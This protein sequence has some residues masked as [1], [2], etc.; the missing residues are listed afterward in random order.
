MTKLSRGEFPMNIAGLTS[1][2]P[3]EQIWA[4]YQ[5][6]LEARGYMLRLRYRPDWVPEAIRLGKDPFDCEDS[7]P[8]EGKVLDATRI[9]DG[10]QVVLKI[11]ELL[12][13]DVTI[14]SFLANEQGAQKHTIS[15]LEWIPIDDT[16]GWMVMPRMRGCYDLP[17]F[18]TVRE[19]NEFLLQVLEGLV[20]LHSKNIA[21]RDICTQNIVMDASRI[22]PGGFHF[23]LPLTS[24]GLDFLKIYTG[25]ESEP[26]Y[27]KTRTEAG[28]TKYYYIDFGLSVRFPSFEARTLVTGNYGRLRKHVPEISD[29]VPYDPFKVDVRLVGEMLRFEFLE[30]YLGL[31]FV[32]PFMKELRRHSPANRPDAAMALGLF[33]QL[34]SR[35]SD[36]DLD[37]PV[38]FCPSV[39]RQT[40]K[41]FILSLKTFDFRWR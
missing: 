37:R 2:L 33:R 9:S 21:H 25:D 11:V 32:I 39:I 16:W 26:H 35:M 29:T 12:S 40:R 4:H 8:G 28:P 7:I 15:L 24:N 34:V 1:L 13:A 36:K 30:H 6:Y 20:F 31:D 14:S 3:E 22:I 18:R 17:L 19:F 5:P 23:V 38:R 41:Q 10:T 27:M